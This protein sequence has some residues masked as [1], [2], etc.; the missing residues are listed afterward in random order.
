MSRKSKRTPPVRKQRPAAVKRG[1]L[2]SRWVLPVICCLCLAAAFGIY[3]S[4]L[5][6][7]FVYDDKVTVEKNE[8]IRDPGNIKVLVLR[9][10]FRPVVNL[11]YAMDYRVSQLDPQAY[12]RTNLILHLL[13]VLLAI[14][15]SRRVAQV[16]LER[17]GS[18]GDAAPTVVASVVGL[19]MAV[20]PM[21][22]ESVSYV[23][24]RSELLSL[25]FLLI[26]FFGFEAFLARR[27]YRLLGL[28]LGF[29]AFVLSLASKESA[30]MLPFLL[31]AW[32]RLILGPEASGARR[33]L[34]TFHLPFVTMIS[35]AGVVRVAVFV[36]IEHGVHLASFWE[37][38]RVEAVVVWRYVGL[39]LVPVAQSLVHDVRPP[40][41]PFDLGVLAAIFALVGACWVMWL[42]RR[43]MPLFVFGLTWFLFLL[44]PSH[45][46]PL[47][48]AM[49]EHRTYGAAFG[50]FLVVGALVGPWIAAAVER[51]AWQKVGV[52]A[53]VVIVIATLASLTVRRNR[54]WGDEVS[55][56]A[57]AA[58]KAPSTWAAQYAYGE[59]LHRAGRNSE[60]IEVYRKAAGLMPEMV[61]A[62]LNLGIC[63]A[64]TGRH[65]EAHAEFSTA[66]A[67]EPHNPKGYNNLGML[68]LMMN[69]PRTAESRFREALGRD[70]DNLQARLM[71]VRLYRTALPAPARAFELCLDIEEIVPG[72]PD[73]RKCI[74]ESGALLQP[75]QK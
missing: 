25:F 71:L 21:M 74:E 17:V 42:V 22:T 1:G 75:P 11:S 53:V 55:L 16:A 47:S 38:L 7:P 60:A 63:L 10:V 5:D 68:A 36:F 13:N 24:G 40:S 9:D 58:T 39:M 54:V 8:A 29:G 14:G 59:A 66:I 2:Q 31:L 49:A 44:A 62:H 37:N 56:W 30:A 65:Q 18:E 61:N 69:Q 3:R 35:I 67:L 70:A 48:E 64:E 32:D 27:K 28:V 12:H 20:H 15:L 51:G 73:I 41:G 46:I 43:K 23:S 26:S 72:R 34:M 57:D 33:R 6:N 4:T 19:L 45:L 52:L 50:F